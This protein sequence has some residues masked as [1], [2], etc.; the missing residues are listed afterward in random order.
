MSGVDRRDNSATFQMSSDLAALSPDSL[1]LLKRFG[2]RLRHARL[3]RQLQLG[4]FAERA[5]ISSAML[6][7]VER[8]DPDVEIRVYLAVLEALALQTDIDKLAVDDPREGQKEN[9][10]IASSEVKSPRPPEFMELPT[11]VELMQILFA[12]LEKESEND[13]SLVLPLP[14]SKP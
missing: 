9:A 3:Q 8:G 6:R 14:R 5:G 11:D 7:K 10:C 2:G 13:W 12:S 1:R 4:Q